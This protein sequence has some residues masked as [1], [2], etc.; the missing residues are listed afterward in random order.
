MAARKKGPGK[1][2]AEAE[3]G[4]ESARKPIP[5]GT[6]P[7]MILPSAKGKPLALTYWDL[8]FAL[9]AVRDCG[10]DFDRLSERLGERGGTFAIDRG[11][12]ERKRSHLRDLEGR[13]AGAGRTAGDMVD[14]AGDPAR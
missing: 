12:V 10:G 7:A 5:L 6:D 1:T 3:T 2:E 11:A 14:A 9:V 4:R 8:W 13:L